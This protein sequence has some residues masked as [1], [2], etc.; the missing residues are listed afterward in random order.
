MKCPYCGQHVFRD[1]IS[2]RMQNIAQRPRPK[3]KGTEAAKEHARK[4]AL[5]R[6]RKAK[7]AR[8]GN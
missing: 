2:R 5:A 1:L 8:A 4:A 6:W 3:V 7:Q